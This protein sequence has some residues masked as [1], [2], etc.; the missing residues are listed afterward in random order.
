MHELSVALRI[1]ELAQQAAREVDAARVTAIHVRVGPLA[2]VVAEA[3]QTAY[4]QARVSSPLQAA[5]LVIELAPLRAYCAT[6]QSA[7]EIDSVQSWEC[8]RCGQPAGALLSGNELE[9]TALEL[10]S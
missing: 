4:D 8:G 1:L 2:G 9:L 6:C 3:L 5:R 10:S 7:V